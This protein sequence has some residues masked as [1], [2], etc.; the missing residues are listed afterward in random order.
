MLIYVVDHL[1]IV[2]KSMK[3][4]EKQKPK[5]QPFFLLPALHDASGW[6]SQAQQVWLL[7]HKAHPLAVQS[8]CLGGA[9]NQQKDGLKGWV[10]FKGEQLKLLF[11]DSARGIPS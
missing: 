2:I 8:C 1:K 10:T 9:A 7:A 6:S 3:L 5:P 11:L 4:A